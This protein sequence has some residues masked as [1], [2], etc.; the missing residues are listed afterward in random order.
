[1][2]SWGDP[3]EPQWL[4][5]RTAPITIHVIFPLPSFNSNLNLLSCRPGEFDDI[6]EDYRDAYK[7]G[8]HGVDCIKL[9]DGCPLGHGLL[10]SNT[11]IDHFKFWSK[12]NF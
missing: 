9:F 2:W 3:A 6:A 7:A 12:E 8:Q 4:G 5:R 10:D 11:I 1:M